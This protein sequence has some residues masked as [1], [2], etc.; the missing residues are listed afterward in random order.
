MN[1]W[2]LTLCTCVLFAPAVAAVAADPLSVRV[3]AQTVGVVGDKIYFTLQETGDPKARVWSIFPAGTVGFDTHDELGRKDAVADFSTRFPGTYVIFVSV[4][5]GDNV[6]QT[7]HVLEMRGDLPDADVPQVDEA[8]GQ[9]SNNGGGAARM[10]GPRAL[11]RKPASKPTTKMVPVKPETAQQKIT[12]WTRE[13]KSA[14][15]AAES[16]QLAAVLK[17]T[18]N[19]IKSGQLAGGDA[20]SQ[21]H[22]MTRLDSRLRASEEAWRP[23]WNHMEVELWPQMKRLYGGE[24]PAGNAAA[25][26]DNIATILEQQ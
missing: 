18:A 24:I 7:F 1:R 8:V 14:N 22:G 15:L 21:A 17:Q 2:T 12:R 23:W 6:A 5:N 26:L 13:V 3:R 4:A 9:P 16:Q 10:A 19:S 25:V 20:M 11:P